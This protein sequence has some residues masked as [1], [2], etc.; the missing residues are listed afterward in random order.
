MFVLLHLNIHNFQG[1]T[2][3]LW[4]LLFYKIWPS[5]HYYYGYQLNFVLSQIV[6]HLTHVYSS[7][8]KM[9][10]SFN[11]EYIKIAKG[12]NTYVFPVYCEVKFC[13]ILLSGKAL[14]HNAAASV[15]FHSVRTSQNTWGSSPPK[16]DVNSIHTTYINTHLCRGNFPSHI[17]Q[18]INQSYDWGNFPLNLPWL[19]KLVVS[20]IFYSFLEY[21]QLSRVLSE[22][23][24]LWAYLFYLTTH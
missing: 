20:W 15:V 12:P 2:Y 23:A 3:F 16:S 4:I 14:N 22:T 1:T 8:V 9:S 19:F 21:Y 17:Y 7:Q 24:L 10:M 13:N 18:K 11:T 5:F 6:T